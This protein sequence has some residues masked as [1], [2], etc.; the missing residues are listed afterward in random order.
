MPYD[1]WRFGLT[2]ALRSL[3]R[4]NGM[5]IRYDRIYLY[6]YQKDDRAR[7]SRPAKALY[8]V[9]LVPAGRVGRRARDDSNRRGKVR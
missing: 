1:G 9:C 2:S 3:N 8:G 5:L 4:S 6:Q 7:P